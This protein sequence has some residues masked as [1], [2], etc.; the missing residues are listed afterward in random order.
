MIRC[1]DQEEA[2]ELENRIL[3]LS[4]SIDALKDDALSLFVAH[5]HQET[6]RD[7][8]AHLIQGLDSAWECCRLEGIVAEGVATQDLRD[9]PSRDR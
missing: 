8:L 1:K 6:L 5:R 4:Q 3:A 9:P 2:A 7:R